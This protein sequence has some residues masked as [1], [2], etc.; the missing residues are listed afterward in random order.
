MIY[1]KNVPNI[2]FKYIEFLAT[3]KWLICGSKYVYFQFSKF[4]QIFSFCVA[5]NTKNFVSKICVLVEVTSLSVFRI[6]FRIY[7]NLKYFLFY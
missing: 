7:G 5:P 4:Y 3:K 1:Q 2:N 6:F